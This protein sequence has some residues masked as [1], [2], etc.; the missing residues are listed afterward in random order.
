[1]SSY[2]RHLR[3][4][5]RGG[6]MKRRSKTRSKTTVPEKGKKRKR[7]G[8]VSLHPLEFDE[9]MRRLVSAGRGIGQR[10]GKRPH[11]HRSDQA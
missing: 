1:V 7:A 3:S 8:P 6:M 2:R 5:A 9:A 4:S 10:E 11:G